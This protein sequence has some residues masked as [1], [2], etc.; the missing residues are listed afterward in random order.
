[1]SFVSIKTK[2]K[3]QFLDT[4][5]Q[6]GSNKPRWNAC[7]SWLLAFIPAH[8]C[9]RY[10]KKDIKFFHFSPTNSDSKTRRF[11]SAETTLNIKSMLRF[12]VSFEYKIKRILSEEVTE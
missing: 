2:W 7:F 5:P 4:A 6:Y 12:G 3:S 11:T 10:C 8:T 9:Q 1:V